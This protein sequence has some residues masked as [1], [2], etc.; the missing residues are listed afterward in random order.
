MTVDKVK[1][2]TLAE[3]LMVEHDGGTSDPI[4][5]I[6]VTAPD[7]LALLAEIDQLKAKVAEQEAQLEQ[8]RVEIYEEATNAIESYKRVT[9]IK[10]LLVLAYNSGYMAGHHDTVEGQFTDI[11]HA[12]MRTHH[13]DMVA[14]IIAEHDQGGKEAASVTITLSGCAFTENELL[15]Q[16]M[17]NIDGVNRYGTQRWVRV[18]DVFGVG[19]GVSHALCRRFGMDPDQNLKK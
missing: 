4:P 7:V 5:A 15:E 11:H 6:P 12:D 8:K 19:S 14:E 18:K 3:R 9:E 17:R 13:L 2:K 10:T 16:V 1:L